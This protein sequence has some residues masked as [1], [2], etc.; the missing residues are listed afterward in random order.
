MQGKKK[1]MIEALK[2]QLGNVTLACK[3][4]GITRDT[5]YR[6]IKE[7]AEYKEETTNLDDFV[8]DYVENELY[9]KISKGDT[10]CILFWLKCKAKHRGYIER[11]D[12][13]INVQNNESKYVL[14]I[15]NPSE[16]K[17]EVKDGITQ[18]AN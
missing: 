8:I 15:I 2:H 4:V 13:Q 6:W 5:H 7:D 14:E 11:P 16:S 9:K 12:T 3:E 17:N 18:R 1:L 10:A